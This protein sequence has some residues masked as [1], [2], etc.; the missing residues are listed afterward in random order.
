MSE[1]VQQIEFDFM[2]ND[3]YVFKSNNL[4]ESN[5]NLTT[6]EQRLVYLA[7]KKLKPKFV[8]SNVKPSELATYAS[9]QSFGNIKIYVNE[10]KKEFGLSGNSFYER[11]SEASASLFDRKFMYFNDKGNFVEKRWVITSEYDKNNN[12]ISITFHPDL[13][14][15]LLI[16]KT[17]YGKLQY[18]VSKYLNT[19][20]SFRMYELLKNYAY[21][22]ERVMSVKEIRQK[23]EMEDKTYADSYTFKINVIDK[24]IE[25][26]NKYSDIN[27]SYDVIRKGRKTDGFKFYI[28]IEKDEM[29]L[30][31]YSER[32]EEE[33]VINVNR[34]VGH[35]LTDYQVN[36]ITNYSLEAIKEFGIDMGLYDF[37]EEKV[38][39]I[40]EYAENNKV[41]NFY[42]M[43]EGAVR[44]NWKPNI[45]IGKNSKGHFNDFEQRDYD[46]GELEKQLLGWDKED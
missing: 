1:D 30:D 11:L 26:I 4:I 7:I 19:N 31:V 35:E 36:K 13:I 27:I 39:I 23:L 32:P 37:I 17:K 38:K 20:Y 3:N 21:K 34:I 44:K 9:T 6:N 14:L 16:F 12:Y 41:A 28:T 43:L 25:L 24:S 15:D 22:G 42:S 46:F 40:N 45:I 33:H 10:F 29:A 18:N 5:Y 2:N 8:K